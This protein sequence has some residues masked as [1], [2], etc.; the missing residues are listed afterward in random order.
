MTIELNLEQRLH[1]IHRSHTLRLGLISLATAAIP[2]LIMA[3]L[4]PKPGGARV[5]FY[6]VNS[7]IAV[8][9]LVRAV[10]FF[11]SLRERGR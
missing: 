7:A 3:A 6:A 9:S 1:R 11:W 10:R 2:V 5:W 4:T 8:F